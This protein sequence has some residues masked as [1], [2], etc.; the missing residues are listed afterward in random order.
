MT[1]V[2]RAA[3]RHVEPEQGAKSQLHGRRGGIEAERAGEAGLDSRL[4]ADVANFFAMSTW[5][6]GKVG[7]G[8][9]TV[10]CTRRVWNALTP[11]SHQA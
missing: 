4:K 9:G 10:R 2:P 7:V 5:L 1:T 3:E 6:F 11:I 8:E